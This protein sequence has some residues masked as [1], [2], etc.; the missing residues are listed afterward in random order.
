M[1]D[2]KKE[3][4]EYMKSVTNGFANLCSYEGAQSILAGEGNR[5]S[6]MIYKYQEFLLE[7]DKDLKYIYRSE[8]HNEAVKK[9]HKK[10]QEIAEEFLNKNTLSYEEY[11][12]SKT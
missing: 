8:S 1:K 6:V 9:F 10:R 3:Y 4:E 2:L 5:I 11:V 12:K 7:Y